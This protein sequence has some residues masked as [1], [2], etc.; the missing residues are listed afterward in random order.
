VKR[1]EALAIVRD[2]LEESARVFREMATEQAGALA[3]AA[4]LI[5]AC[6][7]AGGS[8]YT[9]G[10][11]GS[12]ADAQHIAAELSG[13]YYLERPPLPATALTVNS[14]ALTAIGNDFGFDQVF[15]RQLEGVGK[16]GDVLLA[17]TTS[18]GSVNVAR[19]VESARR[20]EMKVIGFTGRRGARFAQNCDLALVVPSDDVARIQEGHI[21]AGHL[22][23]QL[24]EAALFGGER[25]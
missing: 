10:N 4:A 3:D 12:A 9:C 18:G 24:V 6:F 25:E 16:K 23:C 22:I 5:E 7:R 2:R 11:G 14:S 21:G 19:A 20:L 1:E 15:S 13:R 8:F 17:I